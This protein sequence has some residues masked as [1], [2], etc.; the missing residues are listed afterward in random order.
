MSNA[1]GNRITDNALNA[2]DGRELI[3]RALAEIEDQLGWCS[4]EEK[5]LFTGVY[6]DTK[7]V[8]SFIV[9]VRNPQGITAVLKLQLRPLPYDEGFIIRHIEG[10]NKSTVIRLP[11]I[12]VDRPWSEEA[13][14]GFVLFE[15]L[16]Q[17]SDL[18]NS[19]R[20]NEDDLVRHGVFLSEFINKL[21]PVT[22]WLSAPSVSS[23]EKYK[24]A[25]QH[26][27]EISQ[28]SSHRHISLEEIELLREQ[29]FNIL[30]KID[31]HD[32]HFTHGH[33]SGKDV[34]YDEATGE[35]ILLANLY[36]SWRPKYY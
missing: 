28:K 20:P 22:A 10:E 35:F 12:L 24:E 18:W 17:L 9:K 2:D 26:F 31:L 23:Q 1:I 16:S 27:F 6:Y 19:I 30:D 14:Y 4:T 15:D 21:L 29:F 8:G 3:Q 13:G 7:K 32:A 34:K 25:F 33:L 11:K 36:W 5:E